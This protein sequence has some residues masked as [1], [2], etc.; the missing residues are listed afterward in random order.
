LPNG[1]HEID[2]VFQSISLFDRITIGKNA[3]L[4]VKMPG[5][6]VPIDDKNTAILAAKAFFSETG[7]KNAGASI[8]IE[9]IIP[10]RS[11]L[12]G[13]SSDA[14][15]VLVGL[16]ALYNVNFNKSKL[17]QIG[18]KL[19][20]DVPFAI[21]GGSARA[22]GIGEKFEFL[23][24][25][26]CWFCV[27]MP[28]GFGVSTPMAY[29]KYDELEN[30]VQP[31]VDKVCRAV[32]S[33]NLEE[34]AKNIGNVF[35]QVKLSENTEKA[36]KMLKENGAMAAMMTGSGAACFGIFADKTAAISAAK[37]MRPYVRNAFVAKPVSRGAKINLN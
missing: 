37:K 34:L 30:P 20:A 25:P 3:D 13:G 29:K 23:S 26:V 14:A 8:K 36:C 22:K 27:V 31:D 18:A 24:T 21:L 6:K 2:T 5:S 7:I 9:K 12:G 33:N 35:E 17:C 16:N 15:A 28:N 11:G 10:T 1:Y 19:G 32:K 4:I